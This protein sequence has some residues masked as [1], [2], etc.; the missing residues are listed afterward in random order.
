G[1]DATV[2]GSEAGDEGNPPMDGGGGG[3]TGMGTD[4][5]VDACMA[6]AEICGDGVDNDCDGVVDNGCKGLGTYVS[7]A[8]GDDM[9]P[10]TKVKPVKTIAQGMKNAQ[11][12]GGK[13]TVYVA[14][15]HYSEKVTMIEG[16]SLEGG[17]HCDM[18]LC[19]WMRNPSM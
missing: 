8:T 16:I 9:N 15:S 3:D 6:V 18:T 10:G 17:Y 2:P 12:I 14:N 13:L 19:D 1:S 7:G 5:G 11:T 4:T